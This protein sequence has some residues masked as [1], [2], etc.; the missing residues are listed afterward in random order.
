METIKKRIDRYRILKLISSYAFFI[1][2]SILVIDI[3]ILSILKIMGEE[4][5]MAIWGLLITSIAIILISTTVYAIASKEVD[6]EIE[7]LKNSFKKLEV[8]DFRAFFFISFFNDDSTVF[9]KGPNRDNIIEVIAIIKSE[10]I[11]IQKIDRENFDKFF[12]IKS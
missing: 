5:Q 6:K 12:R 11:Q 9:L 4:L 1:G 10:K 3:I 7:N 2:L 8:K